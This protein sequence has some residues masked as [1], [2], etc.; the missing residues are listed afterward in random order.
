MSTN[1]NELNVL[2]AADM[3]AAQLE[4]EADA[5]IIGSGAGGG[6]NA[7]E[8]AKAGKK[9]IV[10][11]AGPYV[12]SEKFTEMMAVSMATMYEGEGAQ[13]NTDGDITVLQGLCVGG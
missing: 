8:L 3:T 4:L 5:V 1:K 12:P 13:S 11:E 2:T 10:L 6:I 7:Y 9:V